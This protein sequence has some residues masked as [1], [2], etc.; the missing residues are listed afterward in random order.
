M[1]DIG[2]QD[3]G[4]RLCLGKSVAWLNLVDGC[5][6]GLSGHSGATVQRLEV[7]ASRDGAGSIHGQT[8][9]MIEDLLDQW[10]LHKAPF[11]LVAP[12]DQTIIRSVYFP[13]KK[14]RHLRRAL[15]WEWQEYFP[16]PQNSFVY[17]CLTLPQ[18]SGTGWVMWIF[19]C[20]CSYL[21]PWFQVCEDAGVVL[22][23]V[24][25]S[26]L[27]AHCASQAE[28]CV[29]IEGGFDSCTV[30]A[31]AE[32][33]VSSHNVQAFSGPGDGSLPEL[34]WQ[35]RFADLPVYVCG[36]RALEISRILQQTGWPGKLM[37]LPEGCPQGFLIRRQFS[38]AT[39][40][41]ASTTLTQVG[42]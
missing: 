23:G 36:Q 2:S 17:D 15:A 28:S 11:W 3:R 30:T 31:F 21:L 16:L 7:V 22:A 12:A 38:A 19:A 1:I 42:A 40:A 18:K 29:I 5:L 4:N 6:Y 13:T 39:V 26:V 34:L 8:A 35:D 24:D 32:D 41:T 37:L 14:K 27:G 25:L 33:E 10:R 9:V 20:P